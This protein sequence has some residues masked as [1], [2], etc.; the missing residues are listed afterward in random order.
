M[1]KMMRLLK[2]RVGLTDRELEAIGH[3]NPL[4]LIGA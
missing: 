4:G 2:D 1:A 3:D